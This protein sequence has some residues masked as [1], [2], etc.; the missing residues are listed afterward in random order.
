MLRANKQAQIV[1]LPW[2]LTG[3][4]TGRYALQ[5]GKRIFGA[6]WKGEWYRWAEQTQRT[7]PV[8]LLASIHRSHPT[9]S[10]E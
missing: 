8:P 5:S 6:R 4:L 9:L 7:E 3:M 1:R 10:E 2:T